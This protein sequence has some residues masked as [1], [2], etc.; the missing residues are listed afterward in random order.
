MVHNALRPEGEDRNELSLVEGDKAVAVAE[1]SVSPATPDGVEVAS[2]LREHADMLVEHAVRE[3]IESSS[4]GDLLLDSTTMRHLRHG[5]ARALDYFVERL[6]DPSAGMDSTEFV[7]HG[8]LQR[9]A[10]RSLSELLGFYRI[11][12]SAIWRGAMTIPQLRDADAEAVLTLGSESAAVVQHLSAASVRGYVEQ[13]EEERRR[14]RSPRERLLT[15]LLSTE[16]IEDSILEMAGDEAGWRLPR[17]LRVAITERPPSPVDVRDAPERVLVDLRGRRQARLVVADD[18]EW[19]RWL[20]RARAALCC[21]RQIVVG[22]PVVPARAAVSAAR[23]DVLWKLAQDGS[24]ADGSIVRCEEH[25][26]NILL[27]ADGELSVDFAR[28]RLAPL[29]V[30]SPN[31]R[32]RAL[33]TLSQWLRHRGSPTGVAAELGIHVQTA[34]YRIRRLHELFGATLDDPESRFELELAVRIAQTVD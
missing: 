3:V 17:R 30:L 2:L 15:L 11:A 12:E 4:A 13:D 22:P 19:E 1:P 20:E 23:A 28:T 32:T 10:E 18:E 26:L 5:C 25:E 34:R 21:S 24:F 7:I 6:E 16:P 31:A 33:E 8:R 29:E 14:A 27:A 9:A